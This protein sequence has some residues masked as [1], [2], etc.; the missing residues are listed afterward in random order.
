MSEN[1][2][3]LGFVAVAFAVA[4]LAWVSKPSGPVKETG[5]RTGQMLVGDFDPLSATSLEIV[6]FDEDT[7]TVKPF[8]VA[9]T[10]VKGKPLWSIPSHQDYPTDAKDQLADVA[11]G[12]MRLKILGIASDSPGDHALYGVVDPNLKTLKVGDTGVG[13]RVT[14]KGAD[15]KDLLSLVIGKAVP[16]KADLRYVRQA[17]DDHVYIVAAKTDKLSTKFESWIEKDLLKLSTWDI[18][19]LLIRDYSVDEMQ[20]ALVQRG[21]MTLDYNDTGDPKWKM[22]KDLKYSER[23]WKPI[24][25]AADE[26]INTAKL[27]EM[28]TALGD[29]K[30]V[31]VSRKPKGLSADLKAAEDFVKNREAVESLMERGFFPARVGDP[32]GKQ[33]AVELFSNEGEVRCDMKDG[34][35]YVLRFGGIAVGSGN[36]GKKDAKSGDAKDEKDKKTTGLNRYLFVTA[37]F[38]PDMIPKPQFEALPDAKAQGEKKEPEKKGK[39]GAAAKSADKPAADKPEGDKPAAEKK[40]S[41]QKAPEAKEPAAADKPSEAKPADEPAKKEEPKKDE[42]MQGGDDEPAAKAKGDDA[43]EKESKPAEEQKPAA[44]SE[45]KPGE[46]AAEKAAAKDP[47]Q[48]ERERIE[49]EN[50]RKQDE[51]DEKV[52]KGQEHVKELNARFADWYY[53]ISDEVYRK[54]HLTRADVVKKKEKDKDKDKAKDAAAG[55]EHAGHDHAAPGAD[56]KATPADELEKLKKEGPGE[57][58]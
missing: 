39:K 32:G 22:L 9:K 11:A 55:D 21:E 53:I 12:L 31:D 18:K 14:M 25:M 4:V 5:D 35:Q 30:I 13:T 47:Q 27:D 52:K 40:E 51:Y 26:E 6:E 7:A 48:A 34:V 37:E 24:T 42:P 54:I 38:N 23:G 44:K 20:G 15:G 29:L 28:K 56:V 49:K 8:K 41:E 1:T 58:P 2:K 19:Q 3:T 10:E 36:E 45:E 46:K 17:G 33:T 57:T 16:D 43:S 50:K